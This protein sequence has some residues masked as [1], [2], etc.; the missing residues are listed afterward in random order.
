[1]G[2]DA[3]ARRRR[4]RT[5]TIRTRRRDDCASIARHRRCS[6]SNCKNMNRCG[7]SDSCFA[8]YSRCGRLGAGCFIFLR[9]RRWLFCVLD[10]VATL[11]EHVVVHDFADL[12]VSLMPSTAP[13]FDAQMA[14]MGIHRVFVLV[15]PS[16]FD[17]VRR[18]RRA[19]KWSTINFVGQQMKLSGSIRVIVL[20][21][22]VLVGCS[23]VPSSPISPTLTSTGVHTT[24]D[25]ARVTAIEILPET[26][27]LRIGQTEFLSVSVVL[28][29]G[30]PPSGPLPIWSTTNPSVATVD[31]D[32]LVKARAVGST[33]VE[34]RFKDVSATRLVSVVP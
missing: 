32:G 24:A 20:F 6:E 13:Q 29:P 8:S 10:G 2:F 15:V 12:G 17:V 30:I 25:M 4:A 5:A 3:E 16:W 19:D 18:Q 34:V 9:G 14:D 7:F 1:M 27:I 21:P 31:S 22:M 33:V 26:A 23:K 28:S 11:Q